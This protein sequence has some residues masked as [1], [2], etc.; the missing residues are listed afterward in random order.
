MP[1]LASA[2]PCEAVRDPVVTPVRDAYLDT[3]R[4]ACLRDEA[5]VALAPHVLIDKPGFHG[6]LGGDL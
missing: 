6:A 4:S 5:F 1:S 3:Q 2:D